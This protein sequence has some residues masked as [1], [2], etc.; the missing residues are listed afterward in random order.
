MY[1]PIY[2][3]TNDWLYRLAVKRAVEEFALYMSGD[4]TATFCKT[5]AFNWDKL[6]V[7]LCVECRDAWHPLDEQ[8]CNACRTGGTWVLC[9]ECQEARHLDRYS[10]CYA[11]NQRGS[12]ND[13]VG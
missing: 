13:V 4:G 11:C 6:G 10:M 9:K 1:E 8:Q 7:R 2:Q 5:C 12:E 3:A